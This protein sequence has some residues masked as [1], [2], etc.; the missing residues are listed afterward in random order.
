[1]AKRQQRDL[2]IKQAQSGRPSFG[3]EEIGPRSVRDIVED[4]PDLRPISLAPELQERKSPQLLKEQGVHSRSADAEGKAPPGVEVQH[5][6][7]GQNATDGTRFDVVSLGRAATR[8]DG[9]PVRIKL[10]GDCMSHHPL[11]LGAVGACLKKTQD[12]VIAPARA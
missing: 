12:L 6:R 4:A 7:V 1:M 10:P 9:V 11:P 8:P 3:A 2:N 5:E